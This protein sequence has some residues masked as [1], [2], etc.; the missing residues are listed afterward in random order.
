MLVHWFVLFVI[1][2]CLFLLTH[3]PGRSESAKG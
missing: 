2:T 3:A 1:P